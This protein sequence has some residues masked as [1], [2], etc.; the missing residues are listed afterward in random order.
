MSV[1]GSLEDLSF[2]DV[3]QIV[4]ASR[5]SG[6]LILTMRD[7]ERRVRFENGLIRSATLGPGG[8]ELHDLLLSRGLIASA[9]LDQAHA[10]A[11]RDGTTVAGAL[12]GAGDVSQ[13]AIER[14]V[15]EELKASLRSLVLSQEGEFRFEVDPDRGPAERVL[16]LVERSVVRRAAQQA[17]RDSGFEVEA[18]QTA[19]RVL[20]RA[21]A[22]AR[23][24]EVFHFVGDL[25]LPND[26][27]DGWQGGLDLLRQ[28]RTL[29]PRAR[30]ILLEDG[31]SESAEAAA[32]ASGASTILSV[33]D[34][35][36]AEWGTIGR[37]LAEFGARLGQAVLDP[38][39]AA[40]GSTARPLRVVDQLS[41]LRGLVGELHTEQEIEI[42]LLVLRLATEYFERGVLFA[43]HDNQAH[44]TGAFGGGASEGA[45]GSGLDGRVRGVAVPLVRGSFLEIAVRTRAP[46]VGAIS[47]RGADATLIERLGGPP[48]REAAVLPVL[49]GQAIYSLLYGDNGD[50]ARPIGDL[51]GLEI[52][53]SQAGI[54]LR[55]AALQRRLATLSSGDGSA[56][57]D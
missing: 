28:V 33:P 18:F 38:D 52:F 43:V 12:V 56:S 41:L 9:A 47:R 21:R 4:H 42:P 31:W 14:L 27:G 2:P 34:L 46:H 29:A 53:V 50:S 54:A 7:G 44:G 40:S 57:H 22:L 17:L 36:G 55:N 13:G 11:A 26:S 5:R 23:E 49:G 32:R 39:R 8:P 20:D 16:L 30:G 48:P 51:R 37:A 6:T 45:A 3:L 19:R 10:R 35:G 25:I 15:R 1:V 24:N